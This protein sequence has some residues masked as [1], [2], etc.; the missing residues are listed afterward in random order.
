MIKNLYKNIIRLTVALLFVLNL[1]V[2]TGLP[3][4]TVSADF[5]SD[6]Q[7]EFQGFLDCDDK[8]TSFTDFDGG[9]EAPDSA[10]F[11]ENLTR[12]GD[13]RTF[14]KNVANFALGFLGLIAILIIIYSG[15]L[16]VTSRGD[17]TQMEKGKKGITSAVIGILIILSSFAIVNTVIQ[18]PG[19]NSRDIED[20][21]G[22][23]PGQGTNIAQ[24]ENYNSAAEEVADLTRALISSFEEF[25]SN[26]IRLQ[27]LTTFAPDRFTTRAEFVDY[28]EFMKDELRALQNSSGSLSNAGLAAQAVIDHVLD[29]GIQII[30]NVVKE[31][32]LEEFREVYLENGWTNFKEGF[33]DEFVSTFQDAFGNAAKQFENY[34]CS[35]SPEDRSILYD[36]AKCAEGAKPNNLSRSDL[37]K[38]IDDAFD[39]LIREVVINKGINNDFNDDL[40]LYT[41]R[42]NNIRD[43]LTNSGQVEL[44][45]DPGLENLISNIVSSM[46]EH[47]AEVENGFRAKVEDDKYYDLYCHENP[48]GALR[49]QNLQVEYVSTTDDETD[50]FM[51]NF[52]VDPEGRQ[53][54][55]GQNALN[56]IKK[57]IKQLQQLYDRL[58][59]IQFTTPIISANTFRGSAPLIVTF[60]GSASYDPA[61]RTIPDKNYEWDPDGDGLAGVES[62]DAGV[63]CTD[64]DGNEKETGSAS[65][66]CIFTRPGS[67]TTSLKVESSSTNGAVAKGVAYAQVRVLP[68]VSKINLVATIPGQEVKKVLKEYAEDGTVKTDLPE[69]E[70]ILSE[71]SGNGPI[72]FDASGTTGN[73]IVNYEWY[74]ANSSQQASGSNEKTAKVEYFERGVYDAYLAVT[75]EQ[76]NVDRKFFRIN[77][78][79][80]VARI[81]PSFTRGTPGMEFIFDGSRSVADLGGIQSYSWSVNGE[82]ITDEDGDSLRYVF[83]TPGT[84]TVSLT[85][86]D[87]ENND[88]TETI[89]VFIESQAPQAIFSANAND[90][91]QPSLFVFDASQSFDPDPNDT[92][93]YTW[94]IFNATENIDYQIIDGDLSSSEKVTILFKKKGTYKVELRVNETRD[95]TRG[96]L[97]DSFLYK[98]ST[99]S[100]DVFVN[101]LIDIKFAED[102]SFAAQ[103]DDELEAEVEFNVESRFADTVQI[104]FGDG[105][106]D[107]KRLTKD[108]NGVGK[109]TFTHV[110][111]TAGR[112]EVVLTGE[113]SN[114]KNVASGRLIIGGGDEPVAVPVIKVGESTFTNV[115]DLPTFY[116]GKEIVFDA[117]GSLSSRGTTTGLTYEWNFGDGDFAS[118]ANGRTTH[119]YRDL[120]PNDGEEFKV[121]LIV[122][123][124]TGESSTVEFDIP[125][126]G[127]KP[128]A[129]S[130]LVTP[131]GGNK[132]P[133]TVKTEVI[134]ASDDDGRITQYRFYYFPLNDPDREFDVQVSSIP[135]ATL[136]VATFG[137]ENDEIEYGF[138]V[139]LTDDEGNVVT[140]REL[141]DERNIRT[142]TAINGPNEPPVARFEVDLVSGNVGQSINFF[143]SSTDPDGDI[144]EYT[145]D[146]DGDGSFVNNTPSTEG[147]QSYVFTKKSPSTGYNV[148]LKVLDDKGAPAV[149]PPVKI[150]IDSVL[151]APTAA[152]IYNSNNLEVQFRN[153]SEA[154]TEHGGRITEYSWDFDLNEDSDGDG[155]PANDEDS[156]DEDPKHTY[157]RQGI[158]RVKL[159]V[160]DNEFNED[161]VIRDLVIQ[162]IPVGENDPVSDLVGGGAVVNQTRNLI[163]SIPPVNPATDIIT[164][165]STGVLTLRFNNLGIDVADVLIDRDIYFDT[166]SGLAGPDGDGVRNND[167]DFRTRSMEPWTA[168]YKPEMQPIRIQVTIIDTAGNVYSDQVD[169]IFAGSSLQAAITLALGENIAIA[170]YIA[171]L[172]LGLAF[173]AGFIRRDK[174]KKSKL[175]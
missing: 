24:I 167:V 76:G 62:T 141:F 105:N 163:D 65:I 165:N 74:F 44:P 18:A 159:T 164:L 111:D 9:L 142:I 70:L 19:G 47:C 125:I 171:L 115:D 148:R 152:F 132:T 162:D 86:T 55:S 154:D 95:D 46:A 93:L 151:D 92:L 110:Y 54:T 156:T 33:K 126:I 106:D 32:E 27:K 120:P 160:K 99:T 133:L 119:V 122:T 37:G 21:R 35:L 17:D 3:I 98:S 72:T 4:Q 97:T 69:I 78:K 149:S 1:S 41:F 25:N 82:E 11:D 96:D 89:D 13:A 59:N 108:S 157:D 137:L 45:F 150:Y 64:T 14:A 121:S 22:V 91:S 166:N 169:V 80:I 31:E 53:F 170:A 77:I 48:T 116:K 8:F 123:D 101:S 146:F 16:Y 51:N 5:C 79:S 139:D 75:D 58:N 15:F 43:L 68:P 6:L 175:M 23:A 28:L 100:Q 7:T 161:S 56:Q 71:A 49:A 103:L 153:N 50:N 34:E 84:N 173:G 109:A 102:Q 20:G 2:F 145:Y 87:G 130:L 42:L 67:F 158:Y 138:C 26:Q 38:E 113:T 63:T 85:V 40:N 107:E 88:A 147:N 30:G 104:D 127:A 112:Y 29:P 129:Q 94:R 83:D 134:G 10:G 66:T 61:A 36:A 172:I 143:S 57:V 12:A 124:S 144:I 140:C 136:N 168:T 90:D 114:D 117:S 118:P 131:V 73:K 81:L 52:G 128:K 60:D 39:E 155:D 135:T 174:N